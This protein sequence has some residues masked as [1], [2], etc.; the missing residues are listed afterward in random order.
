MELK[1]EALAAG[2]A[3]GERYLQLCRDKQ[4]LWNSAVGDIGVRWDNRRGAFARWHLYCG[5]V[6]WCGRQINGPPPQDVP[7]LTPRTC[8]YV[9]LHSKEGLSLLISCL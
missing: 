1:R 7:A 4:P 9:R 2:L 6:A 8:E 5:Q 3:S